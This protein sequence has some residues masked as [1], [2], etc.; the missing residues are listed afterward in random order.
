MEKKQV[1]IIRHLLSYDLSL[2]DL[3][4]VE[5]GVDACIPGILSLFPAGDNKYNLRSPDQKY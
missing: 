2:R 5:E 1:A 3:Y 4:T